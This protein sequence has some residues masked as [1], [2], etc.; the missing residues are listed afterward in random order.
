[1]TKIT[2]KKNQFLYSLSCKGH[3]GKAF[4]GEDVLCSAI[5]SLVQ[6]TYL[7]LT[8]VLN[9]N[10]D[11]KRNEH[12]GEFSFELSKEQAQK[13]SLLMETL[14]VSLKDI[15]IGNEKFMKVE[16]CNEVY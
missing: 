3:T 10:V 16:V 9:F 15:E 8:K 11:F 14:Y 13:A 5:S 2:F 1:M 7:G 12:K 6:S 4:S